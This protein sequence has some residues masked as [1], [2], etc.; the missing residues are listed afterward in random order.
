MKELETLGNHSQFKYEWAADN[1]IRIHY[2][3]K[4]TIFVKGDHYKELIQ[5]FRGHTVRIHHYSPD[6]ENLQDWLFTKGYK[7][8]IEQYIAAILCNE[9]HAIES[10]EQGK[11][12][13]V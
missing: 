4:S 10:D 6:E 12:S 3:K 11:I 8:R 1:R 9:R 13:V 7:T 2:G 5:K